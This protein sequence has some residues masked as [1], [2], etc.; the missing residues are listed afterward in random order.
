M[1]LGA[2]HDVNV[3]AVDEAEDGTFGAGEEL[4]DDDAFAGGAEF[5]VAHNAVDG[6]EGIGGAVADG[7]TFAFGEAGG[8]YDAGF[9]A[10]LDVF[11]GF[12]GVG[13]AAGLGGGDGLLAHHFLGEPLVG[14]ELGG[15][16]VGAENIDL[17]FGEAIGQAHGEGIFGADDDELDAVSPDEFFDAGEIGGG[18]V[19]DDVGEL[20]D[21]GVAGG[22]EELGDPGGGCQSPGQ[23]VF[24]TTASDE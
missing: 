4:F 7:D 18:K 3:F 1:V 10:V 16:F 19:G 12:G 2:F 22:G 8:F 23:C 15:G 24:A 6:G 11:L 17:G 20:G 9:V 21:A 13:E 14:F 5:F